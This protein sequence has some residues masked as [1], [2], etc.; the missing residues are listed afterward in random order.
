MVSHQVSS[1]LF[2]SAEGSILDSAELKEFV[3]QHRNDDTA[4]LRLSAAGKRFEFDID[5]ALMQID[6]RK[7]TG[8]KLSRYLQHDGF[9]FPSALSAQQASHQDIGRYHAQKAGSGLRV[10]DLTAGLGIDAM[11]I[12]TAGNQVVAIEIEAW[13]CEVLRHNASVM[14]IDSLEVVCG[15]AYSYIYEEAE[16][17]SFDL[18]FIDPAR[19]DNENRKTHLFADCSPDINR[20]L[21]RMLEIAPTVVVK[22][23]P[24]LDVTELLRH[25]PQLSEITAVA[26]HGECK[27]LL[28]K[29]SR[30]AERQNICLKAENLLSSAEAEL[31]SFS[32]DGQ[33]ENVH[34]WNTQPKRYISG[35]E[36]TT[37]S[38]GGWWL[39]EPNAAVMKL[40]CWQMIADQFPDTIK[41]APATHLYVSRRYLED[42]PGRKVRI[43]AT[44]NS[45]ELKKLKGTRLT[46]VCRNYPERAENLRKRYGLAEGRDKFL[47]AF[48]TENTRMT[49][50][51]E[52]AENRIT[53]IETKK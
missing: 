17:D 7:Q 8:R 21:D 6:C 46:V 40:G 34:K 39:Y 38:D 30:L 20:M 5:F 49:L 26:W 16:P 32:I 28:L 23:S 52:A 1:S 44:P 13:K 45:R 51:G 41:I 2:D 48:S 42:F 53:G 50:I 31:F 33:S 36:L 35:E 15:D 9:Y 24:L 14:R 29:F 19:R 11:E 10:L 4:G 3:A 47:Y 12:A 37:L 25:Y 43:V 22:S 18:I 27:E